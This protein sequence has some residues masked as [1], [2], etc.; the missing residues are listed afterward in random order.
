[1][2]HPLRALLAAVCL[3]AAGCATTGPACPTV[4]AAVRQE[5]P[6][7]RP[8]PDCPP[9]RPYP[10]RNVVL[11]GG[12]VKGIAYAGAFSVLDGQGILRSVERVAGT[13]AGAIQ[14]TLLALDYSPAEIE[15]LLFHLDF[16]RFEDGGATGFLRFFRRFGWFRGDYYLNLMRCL[17]AA[18]AGDPRAT[19]ADL[20]RLGLRDL[21]VF[22]TD[23]DSGSAKE[24]SYATTPDFEVALAA[25]MSGSFPLF[26]A[27]VTSEGDVFVDGGVL[28]NYPVDAFDTEAGLDYATLGFVLENTGAPPP[29]RPV[30]DVVQ[31]AEAL[32]ETLLSVQ[33]QA[34]STDP[35][36]LERTVIV[37]DLGVS[38]LDFELTDE[39]KL[40][41]IAQGAQCTC[42]YLRDWHRWQELRI[43][44]GQR[45]LAPGET[46]PIANR[47]ACGSA[48]PEGE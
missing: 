35:P 45:R 33:V 2:P 26:F 20:H 1:M 43:R 16:A 19:F 23:L 8:E 34:L 46:I 5:A 14:A 10:F 30:K 47:K 22:S 11:E 48:F 13:S 24:F 28:R 12:G 15:S 31:Y 27:S 25:R 36:N 39:Q 38:T 7:S 21:H 18:K 32:F 40:D 44:P 17:V 4:A 42:N 3:L 41:L 29:H 9:P 37:N 6:A